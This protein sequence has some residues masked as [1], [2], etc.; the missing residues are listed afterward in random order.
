MMHTWLVLAALIACGD[1]DGE[2][3]GSSRDAGR[4][5]AGSPVDGGSSDAGADAAVAS[6][7]IDD[8][9]AILAAGDPTEADAI[10]QLLR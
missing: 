6:G 8:V 2:G 10:M 5:D 1:D 9:V 3:G 4:A 7:R